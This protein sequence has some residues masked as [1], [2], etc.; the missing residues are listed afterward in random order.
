MGSGGSKAVQK[1]ASSAA[2]KEA[3]SAAAK[4]VSSAV[5]TEASSAAAKEASSAVVKEA[6]SA[7]SSATDDIE[8]PQTAQ[9]AWILDFIHKQDQ[10]AT[11]RT[12]AVKHASSVQKVD[13]V[14]VKHI[15]VETREQAE[16]A[17]KKVENGLSFGA[18]AAEM[19]SCPSKNTGGELGWIAPG[20]TDKDFERAAFSTDAVG[21]RQ[22]IQSKHGFHVMEVETIKYADVDSGFTVALKHRDMVNSLSSAISSSAA[23]DTVPQRT[24]NPRKKRAIAS[25]VRS[26]KSVLNE[27]AP[28]RLNGAQTT[29]IINEYYKSREDFLANEV[30]KRYGVQ[31]SKVSE[32]VTYFETFSLRDASNH[33]L[34]LTHDNAKVYD[35]RVDVL[36]ASLRLAAVRARDR[37]EQEEKEAKRLESSKAQTAARGE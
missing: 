1:V 27:V 24:A 3:S 7:K 15:L 19:S 25:S 21:K 16:N 18:V 36:S 35:D 28:G 9:A 37:L 13:L 14:K 33:Y 11:E 34:A 22:I 26:M 31:E 30:A 4:E 29:D 8:R 2:V 10:M 17:L 23:E 20:K 32:V 6:G 12:E 5:A